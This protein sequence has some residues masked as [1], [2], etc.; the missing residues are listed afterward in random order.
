LEAELPVTSRT[1][2]SVP[3]VRITFVKRSGS[4]NKR[5]SVLALCVGIGAA[6]G[7]AVTEWIVSTY[8]IKLIIV[9]LGGGIGAAIGTK[10]AQRWANMAKLA[11]CCRWTAW[12]QIGVRRL[13]TR[14]QN[15]GSI[16]PK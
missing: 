11:G 2:P 8:A 14:K 3:L 10:L 4:A 13:P 12:S 16:A 9:A 7:V 15:G 6:L 1:Q 5:L